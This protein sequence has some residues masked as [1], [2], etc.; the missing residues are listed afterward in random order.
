M[1][2]FSAKQHYEA[3]KFTIEEQQIASADLMERAGSGIFNW[4]KER[5]GQSQITIA[6]F[7]GIGNNGGDGLVVARQ[8]LESG[9]NVVVYIVNFSEK[10][11]EDFLLNLDRLKNMGHWPV[12]LSEE[13]PEFPQLSK[14]TIVVDAIFGIGLSRPP[15]TWVA[16][17]IAQIN[18]SNAFVLSIDLPSGL[19]MEKVPEK[20]AK[21][22]HSN[23]VISFQ[24]PK[25]IFFL[26]E[27][28][29]FLNSWEIIDIGLSPHFMAKEN[30]LA[31]LITKNKILSFYQPRTKYAHKGTYGH[32]LI[33]GGSRGKIGAVTLAAR[34]CLSTGAGRVSA[35]TP[36]CGYIPLQSGLP[37]AMAE[38]DVDDTIIT[39]I[40][41]SFKPDV[42]AIGMG[43]GKAKKTVNALR[44]FLETQKGPLVIDADALNIL[45]EHRDLIKLIPENAV[46]TPHPGELKRLIGSWKDDFDKIEKSQAFAK[47]NNL[48]LIVKGAHTLIFK[49]HNMYVNTTGNPGM[50]TAGSGDVLSGMIA[51]LIAQ[52]YNAL[53]AALFGVYLHGR[54][55]DLA[56]PST[57]YQALTAGKI[58]DFIGAAF[59]D[60]F[61]TEQQH[62]E[63]G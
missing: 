44:K 38:T 37:E 15:S 10:R 20:P 9:Y 26:P 58:I 61:Q 33:A 24:T 14:E 4:L 8:L 41:L 18:K 34:A 13:A 50:A 27:T 56:I 59:I 22:V 35:F 21:V 3:D 7:C 6:V 29:V 57:G 63:K 19:Y 36:A 11:S 54:A 48:I 16:G 47:E 49:E 51:A 39:D 25:L 60:L 55:A 5:L 2:I 32:C 12:F 42:V 31:E 30:P 40:V 43:M 45:S 28:G 1:K 17:I 53:E 23:H 46:L 52:G 62:P